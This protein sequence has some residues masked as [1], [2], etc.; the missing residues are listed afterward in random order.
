VTHTG[1][2]DTLYQRVGG[3]AFFTDLVDR[4]YASVAED[5][6]LRPLYPTDL[7]PSRHW[8]TEFLIQYWG[9]PH[10]YDFTRGH[11]RLRMRHA[12]FAIGQAERDQWWTHMSAAVRESE[13]SEEDEQA[14]LSYFDMASTSLINR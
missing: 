5:P 7:A 4:F 10:R 8:L 9:G 12:P 1:G 6:V 14:L 13:L 11:P 3:D 2:V